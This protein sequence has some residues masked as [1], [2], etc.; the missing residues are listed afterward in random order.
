[1]VF[2]GNTLKKMHN[3]KVI[4]VLNQVFSLHHKHLALSELHFW[5]PAI[6]FTSTEEFI[7]LSLN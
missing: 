1:M 3:L 6:Y 2:F 5:S 4:L 7:R